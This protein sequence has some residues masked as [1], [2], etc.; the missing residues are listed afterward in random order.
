MIGNM[1]LRS[2]VSAFSLLH[3]KADGI[4]TGFDI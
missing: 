2:L 4:R 3:Y 1:N